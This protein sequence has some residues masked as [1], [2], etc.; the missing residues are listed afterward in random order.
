MPVGNVNSQERGAG[1]RYNDGKPQLDL[2]PVWIISD[3]LRDADRNSHLFGMSTKDIVMLLGDFQAGRMTAREITRRLLTSDLVEAARVLEYGKRKYAAWNWIKGMPWSVPLGCALRHAFAIIEGEELDPESGLSHRGHLVCNLVMLAQFERTYPEG[4][5]RPLQWLNPPADF[6]EGPAAPTGG[7]ASL[8]GDVLVRKNGIEIEQPQSYDPPGRGRE[9]WRPDG[10]KGRPEL[11][12]PSYV[13]PLD[14][15]PRDQVEDPWGRRPPKE[16]SA[17][18]GQL[19]YENWLRRKE[20]D[21]LN[22]KLSET[23]STPT[24]SSPETSEASDGHSPSSGGFDPA[25]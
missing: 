13:K 25:D 22:R 4:D 8:E 1:A 15:T 20:L 3:A 6:T 10:Y 24:S 14:L 19:M 16:L 21:E 7:Y 18:A 5:D 9:E 23:P 12:L 17:A 11:E 2:I